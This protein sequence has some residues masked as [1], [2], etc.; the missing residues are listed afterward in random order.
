MQPMA[1]SNVQLA[2]KV[3]G[4][5]NTHDAAPLQGLHP[6]PQVALTPCGPQAV[7][8]VPLGALSYFG[9]HLARA[10]LKPKP[11]VASSAVIKAKARQATEVCR[12]L[13]GTEPYLARRSFS[14]S[15]ELFQDV[16]RLILKR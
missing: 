15:G 5:R 3:A 4:I 11:A 8:L 1:A 6:Q 2:V 14:V 12:P 9:A 13:A 7:V 10:R 16:L